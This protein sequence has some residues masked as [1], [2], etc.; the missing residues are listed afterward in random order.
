MNKFTI[1]PMAAQGLLVLGGAALLTTSGAPW[2][3][4]GYAVAG[5][6]L[7][8]LGQDHSGGLLQPV[9]RLVR[10]HNIGMSVEAAHIGKQI[11]SAS[12]H[13][14][15]QQ[16]LTSHIY[17]LTAQ[18][19]AEVQQV[20]SSI[21][22]IAGYATEL[23]NGMATTRAD[24]AAAND[25]AREAA[26]VM[27][28]FHANIGKLLEG[29]S[30]TL[31][32]MDQIS[33][34]SQ[35]TN[36]L[37]INASIEAARAGEMGRGFAVVAAEVRTLAART[38]A[39]ADSVTRQVQ[40]IQQH[41]QHTSDVAAAITDNISQTCGVMGSTTRQLDEFAGSSARVSR[42]IDAIRGIVDTVSTNNDT[43]TE[44]VGQMRKLS[45]EMAGAMD[46]CLAMSR[47]LTAAAQDGMS[48]LGKHTLGEEAFDHL[49]ARLEQ[50]HRACE[51]GLQQLVDQGYDVFDRRFQPIAGTN[52]QQYHTSYDGAYEKLFQ[53]LF[54][55]WAA[56]VPGCDLAVMCTVGDVYPP[57]H[58][59]KYCQRPTGDVAH[60][61]AHCRDKRF[62]NG[63]EMLSKVAND[64]RPFQFQAY[65]R[66]IGD[67]FVLVSKPVYVNGRHWGGFMFAL[68]H[69]ALRR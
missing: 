10:G 9:M 17:T 63:N 39:L 4:L 15:R 60:D 40:A 26:D 62:H 24:V 25:K 21:N 59:S 69:E 20:Q 28:T 45:Q 34:I 1:K 37:S 65:M 47:K 30:S 19:S 22:H 53:P 64:T 23:A 12:E 18:S 8:R 38:R 61:T 5:V 33:G 11:K 67:I 42:E 57:T 48:E 44:N 14:Q 16:D 35:Q 52:P 2:W 6:A 49:I 54:D 7:L 41:S 51:R 32:L 50:C 31:G 66:D 56:S 58:V 46:T 68:E 13:S 36:L 29:T 55:A 27:Q 3:A 43:I